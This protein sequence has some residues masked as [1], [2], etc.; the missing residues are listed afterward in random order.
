VATCFHDLG[1]R[2]RQ[3]LLDDD[4]PA[5]ALTDGPDASEPG[6]RVATMHVM[7]GLEFRCVALIGVN[8]RGHPF[9]AAITA[10]DVDRIQHEIDMLSERSLLFVACTRA[11]EDLY[12]S[13]RT[14]PS[15]LL[16]L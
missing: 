10:A 8:E 4:I 7:K 1:T 16:P 2:A 9:D 12:I 13:W 6:V 14:T 3:R 5:V 11:R 15:P